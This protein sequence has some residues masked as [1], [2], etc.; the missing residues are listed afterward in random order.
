MV[1]LPGERM[2]AARKYRDEQ[3]RPYLDVPPLIEMPDIRGTAKKAYP[4]TWDEQA[5]L[6]QHLP[7]HLQEMALFAVHTGCRE[8][9]IVKLRWRWEIRVP[10]IV[11]SVFLIPHDFGGRTDASGVKNREDRLVVLNDVAKS[12]VEGCR[13]RHSEFVFVWRFG[14]KGQW[15]PT[16]MMNNSGWQRAR[17]NAWQE[18]AKEMSEQGGCR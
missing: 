16:E 7:Q 15:R 18:W 5:R 17:E 4:M 2:R 11:S 6:M 1:F 13:G 3:G 8:Q 14:P 9:E 10:E 12:V